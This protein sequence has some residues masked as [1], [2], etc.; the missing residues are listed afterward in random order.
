M[1][2][3]LTPWC[4]VFLFSGTLCAAVSAQTRPEIAPPLPTTPGT[5]QRDDASQELIRQQ[6]RN[7]DVRLLE[8]PAAVSANRLPTGESPCFTIDH[9]VLRGED[10][11]QFQWA[12]NVTSR[13]DLGAPDSPLGRCLGSTFLKCQSRL[14]QFHNMFSMLLTAQA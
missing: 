7:P 2:L 11:A 3:R 5:S 10:A 13:D 1:H 12:L 6:E 9:L 8:A 4:G 14:I